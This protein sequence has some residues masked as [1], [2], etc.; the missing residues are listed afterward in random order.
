ML[1]TRGSIEVTNH[2]ATT[3]SLEYRQNLQRITVSCPEVHGCVQ[4]QRVQSAHPRRPLLA[5]FVS[6]G[7]ASL[8]GRNL[9]H[10]GL[11]EVGRVG[12]VHQEKKRW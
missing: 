6:A 4:G 10:Q 11:S 7:R 3:G 12:I 9:S 2:H 8:G 5:R 1:A